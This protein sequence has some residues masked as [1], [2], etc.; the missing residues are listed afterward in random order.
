MHTLSTAKAYARDID[1][2][3]LARCGAAKASYGEV[4]SYLNELR[5]KQ[6]RSSVHRQ[7]QSIKK[8]YDYLLA[9]DQ[10]EDHPC[11]TLYLRDRRGKEVQLQ[12]LF[13]EVELQS[14]LERE[15]RYGL[16]K[17]R[18]QLIM[19]LL[20]FQGL[21]SGELIR[22]QVEDVDL[23]KGE[24]FI[25]A[26]HR[27]NERR[28]SLRPMQIMLAH[29]YLKEDRAQLIKLLTSLNGGQARCLLITKKGTEENGEGISYLVSTLQKRF[30]NRKL[31][32]KTI[33]MSVIANKLASG[34]GL[35][36]VQLFAGHKYPSSTERYRQTNLKSLQEAINKCH[37]LD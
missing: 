12:D 27:L 5:A 10:R 24:L 25:A 37:P 7:L 16:L 32:P 20:I 4:L 9:T 23:E 35:R 33:R 36:K 34:E 14:L 1:K 29:R 30:R 15:E 13:T 3:L 2:Y 6:S 17:Y 21:T 19:S 8:Y 28:L 18:N 26:S 11:S 22:L 31:N